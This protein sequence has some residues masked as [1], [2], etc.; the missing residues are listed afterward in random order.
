MN[1]TC[2]TCRWFVI[3]EFS[4]GVERAHGECRNRAPVQGGTSRHPLLYNDYWCG[5]HE[6][7]PEGDYGD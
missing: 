7:D 1:P 4:R 5:D 6:V 2:K 3:S